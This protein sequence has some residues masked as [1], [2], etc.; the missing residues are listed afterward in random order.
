MPRR[1]RRSP[2]GYGGGNHERRRVVG[3]VHD[4]LGGG[5]LA[6]RRGPEQNAQNKN[7]DCAQVSEGRNPESAGDP[8]R[9]LDS[10]YTRTGPRWLSRRAGIQ[11]REARDPAA[12][13]GRDGPLALM[14]GVESRP[15]VLVRASAGGTRVSG[16]QIARLWIQGVIMWASPRVWSAGRLPQVD[17]QFVRRPF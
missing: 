1:V 2:F 5:G 11:R 9:R 8:S 10:R 3:H 12:A 6:R 17:K 7:E 14:E 13:E 4:P 15:N 16:D